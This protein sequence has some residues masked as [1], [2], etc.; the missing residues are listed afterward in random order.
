MRFRAL[1]CRCLWIPLLLWA[2]PFQGQ[3]TRPA[4]PWR[5]CPYEEKV[6]SG[7]RFQGVSL[8]EDGSDPGRSL[9]RFP[10]E[11]PSPRL[12]HVYRILKLTPKGAIPVREVWNDELPVGPGLECHWESGRCGGL[13]FLAFNP[14]R[15]EAYLTL[16]ADA[17][18]MVTRDLF[19]VSVRT[20]AIRR[21]GAFA[22]AGDT[23]REVRISPSGRYLSFLGLRGNEVIQGLTLVEAESGHL[24]NLPSDRE[25]NAFMAQ[26]PG[27]ALEV[28]EYG[29]KPKDRVA[30][31]QKAM[32]K[33]GRSP[34]QGRLWK[35][36]W[37]PEGGRQ[38]R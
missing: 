32:P 13:S 24:F 10:P 35:R 5:E 17:A 26:C 28:L 4:G 22:T 21:L 8:A 25:V 6:A 14:R 37:T 30:Y 29:W 20:G 1:E 12:F 9:A 34:Q 3:E 27:G 7:Y 11:G 36:V 23:L 38:P 19:A 31:L 33:P 18:R 15:E 16:V 2:F